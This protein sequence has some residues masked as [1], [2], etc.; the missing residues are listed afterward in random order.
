[1]APRRSLLLLL[2]S[3]AKKERERGGGQSGGAGGAGWRPD[4]F[5]PVGRTA[6]STTPAYGRDVASTGWSEAGVSAHGRGEGELGR[7]AEQAEREA[8]RPSSACP[9]SPFFE[10]LFSILFPNSF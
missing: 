7:A 5:M 6:A 2:H 9:L 1:M 8:S 3:Q 4:R 10:L